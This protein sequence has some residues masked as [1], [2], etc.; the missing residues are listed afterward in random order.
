MPKTIQVRHSLTLF[1]SNLGSPILASNYHETQHAE[2]VE[3]K[4]S[5]KKH[6]TA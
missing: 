5:L 2:S 3:L 4:L 1:E 6:T